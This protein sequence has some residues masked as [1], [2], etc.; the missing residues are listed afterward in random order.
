MKVIM[1]VLFCFVLKTTQLILCKKVT[2]CTKCANAVSFLVT[3]QPFGYPAV[4]QS[5][6]E[7]S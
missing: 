2:E 3:V 6:R 5:H 1:T 4:V 7:A